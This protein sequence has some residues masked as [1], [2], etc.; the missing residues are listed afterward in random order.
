M[1]E[2]GVNEN[3]V[4]YVREGDNYYCSYYIAEGVQI[5]KEY[6]NV[7]LEFIETLT[8]NDIKEN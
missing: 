4:Y 6:K 3:G 1:I 5:E 7:T 8:Y 2:N